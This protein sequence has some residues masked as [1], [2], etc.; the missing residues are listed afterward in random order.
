M[1]EIEF[2]INYD[3]PALAEGD[4][5]VRELAPALLALGELFTE[6]SLVAYPDR[7]PVSLSMRATKRGSFVA[8]LAVHSPDAWDQIMQLLS[9]KAVT[10]LTN[11]YAIIAGTSASLFAI[12]K[13]IRGRQIVSKEKLESGFIRVTLDDGKTVEGMA[14]AVALYERLSARENAKEVVEPLHRPGVDRLT[15]VPKDA[16]SLAIGEEDLPAFDALEVREEILLDREDEA[17]LTIATASFAEGYKWRFS[18]GDSPFTASIDDST[19]RAR[20]DAGEAFRKGDTLHVRMRVVTT[21]RGNKM[22]VERTVLQVVK[23]IPRE[24]QISIDAELDDAA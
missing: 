8:D 19:F 4:M 7:E 16:E 9:G 10:A 1:A 6:A 22:H 2:S 12:T 18:E 14:E 3:G 5:A 21:Q 13:L 11:L 15:F 17:I 24:V 23:H 20:I